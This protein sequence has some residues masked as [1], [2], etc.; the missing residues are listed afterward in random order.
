MARRRGEAAEARDE[1]GVGPFVHEHDVGT[2]QSARMVEALRHSVGSMSS[3]KSAAE[4]HDCRRA[5]ACEQVLPAPAIDRFKGQSLVA[6]AAADRAA[7]RAGNGR[8]RGSSRKRANGCKETNRMA[9]LVLAWPW[10]NEGAGRRPRA[11]SSPALRACSALIFAVLA[12]R[13]RCKE[14]CRKPIGSMHRRRLWDRWGRRRRPPR[15][16]ARDRSGYRPARALRRLA[17]LRGAPSRMVHR[18]RAKRRSP[19]SPMR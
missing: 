9:N 8:C 6:A 15:P 2:V 10:T 14:H 3:G 4:T 5:L 13:T 16:K 1:R 17:R 18:S 11:S 7:R 19:A 12:W